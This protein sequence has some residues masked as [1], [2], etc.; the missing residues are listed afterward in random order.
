M[1]LDETTFS[2]FR[3]HI[4]DQAV[5]TISPAPLRAGAI[6]GVLAAAGLTIGFV[7]AALWAIVWL[8]ITLI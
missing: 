3:G 1:S 4:P 2:I 7:A 8:A 5:R 6:M